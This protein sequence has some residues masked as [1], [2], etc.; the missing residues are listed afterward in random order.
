MA[1]RRSWNAYSSSRTPT[2]KQVAAP[3][4]R[5]RRRQETGIRRISARAGKREK[6]RLPCAGRAERVGGRETGALLKSFARA[7][8]SRNF[9]SERTQPLSLSLSLPSASVDCRVMARRSFARKR[10]TAPINVPV[11]CDTKQAPLSPR[12]RAQFSAGG[13]T[14]PKQK[15]RA[16]LVPVGTCSFR[17]V[18]LPAR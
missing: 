11:P 5:R 15:R 14:F 12:R 3:R 7:L 4:S 6:R 18:K 9:G 10:L 16:P 17:A 2:V 13:Q 8:L 1:A